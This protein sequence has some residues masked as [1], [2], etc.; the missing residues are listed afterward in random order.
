[1]FIVDLRNN[2]V[3]VWNLTFLQSYLGLEALEVV[4]SLYDFADGRKVSINI[5]LNEFR[6]IIICILII[7]LLL[8]FYYY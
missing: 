7:I 8:L 2:K 3:Y 6:T 4:R 5:T 1:M